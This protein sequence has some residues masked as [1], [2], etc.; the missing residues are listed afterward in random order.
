M[1]T[2]ARPATVYPIGMQE[3]LMS[4]TVRMVGEYP[5]LPAGSVMRCVARAARHAVIAGTPRNQIP[6]EAERTARLA[7]AGRDRAVAR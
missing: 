3:E 5:E 4:L 2:R 1:R 6:G 7:L